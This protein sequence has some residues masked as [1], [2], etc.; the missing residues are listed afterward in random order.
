[1]VLPLPLPKRWPLQARKV[2]LVSACLSA[3]SRVKGRL[4]VGVSFPPTDYR[5][6][7]LRGGTPDAGRPADAAATGTT[8]DQRA[9]I[10]SRI[11]ARRDAVCRGSR[12]PDARQVVPKVT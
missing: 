1:M 12:E 8:N 5:Q 3:R 11:T 6:D 2:L 10:R 9:V 7:P 4:P